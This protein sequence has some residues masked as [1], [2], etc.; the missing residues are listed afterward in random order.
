MKLPTIH[1]LDS[2]RAYP[3]YRYLWTANFCANT[4]QWL[5]LLTLGW[6]VKELTQFDSN[7][8]LLVVGVG[9][10]AALPGV[11]I[12][13]WGGVLGDRLDRRKLVI[14]LELFMVALAFSFALLVR[15]E[16]VLVWHVYAFALMA[17][18]CEALK[19]PVRQALIAN[20]V[21]AH[22]LSNAYATSVLTIPG[23]RMIGP[24]IGGIIVAKVGFFWNFTIEA[25]LY[26]GV[27]IAL[28]PMSTPYFIRREFTTKFGMSQMLT[29]M[30][31]GFKYLWNKQRSLSLIYILSIAPNVV[32]HPVLFLLPLFTTDVLHRDVDYGGYMMAVNGAGGLL[33]VLVFS[34]F[35]FPKWRGMICIVSALGGALMAILLSQSVWVA[36][37]FVVLAIFGATQ[38]AFRTTNGVLTQTLAEDH[39]RVRAMSAYR[40]GMGMVVFFSIFV[41]WL[42]G[43]I[44]VQPTLV[45]MGI[46]GIFISIGFWLFSPSV[47]NQE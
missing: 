14:S 2:L 40:I 1:T 34:A 43:L 30:A 10:T 22:A 19:M 11:I 3:D 9:G 39:Y 4:A 45:I 29:D 21:P 27:I 24:F 8:A 5:Q 35:G 33:M 20:T 31:D 16:F 15:T 13:P 41:G 46:I 32:L 12:G 36:S 42:A 47:R 23:T 44:S 25:A 28:I 37:A 17:G 26:L 38:T 7:S 18:S 6:L